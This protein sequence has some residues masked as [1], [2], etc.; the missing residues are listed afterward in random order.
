MIKKVLL[1]SFAVILVLSVGGALFIYMAVNKDIDEHFAGT[2]TALDLPGSGED[3]Q[4]DR[5]RGYA[6]LSVLDRAATAA[7]DT[8][9]PGQVMRIDLYAQPYAAF[10]A[11]L[12]APELFH[13]HGLSLFIDA[14]D[15]RHLL[16]INHPENRGIDEEHIERFTEETPGEFRHAET[17]TTPLIVRPNDLVAVGPRQFYVAQDVAQGSGVTETE[18]IYFNGDSYTVV[19]SDIQSG[20]GINVSADLTT[21]YIAE[22]GGQ[23]VRVA[24]LN[25][26]GTIASSSHIDLGTSPDNIDVAADGSLWVGGHSNLIALVMHFIAGTK[27]PTQILRVSIDGEES[28]VEEIYLNKGEQIS[29]GSGGATLGNKLLIGSITDKKVLICEM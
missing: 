10:G 29:S 21:L 26:D 2:C 23:R 3:I 25:G 12:D 4:I 5:E 11:L 20:G 24:R 28:V 14:A 17:F 18:L 7:G 6:Y 16:I 13:P 27:A 9:E 8:A 22:T 1:G 15:Q 19:A